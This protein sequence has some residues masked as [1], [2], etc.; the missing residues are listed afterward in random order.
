M[1]CFTRKVFFLPGKVLSFDPRRATTANCLQ[2]IYCPKHSPRSFKVSLARRSRKNAFLPEA[3]RRS[4]FTNDI[5]GFI[6]HKSVIQTVIY[7]FFNKRIVY[8]LFLWRAPHVKLF[9]SK[10]SSLFRPA[11]GCTGGSFPNCLL[12]EAF[13]RYHIGHSKSLVT[14]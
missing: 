11:S 6:S 9:S 2:N 12:S 3:F 4:L 8:Q 10:E 1:A 5:S 7:S 14:Q 13:Q